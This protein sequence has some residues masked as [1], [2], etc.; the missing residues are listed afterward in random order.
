VAQMRASR[1]C[2]STRW[3]PVFPAPRS[4]L[5]TLERFRKDV[6]S[7]RSTPWRSRWPPLPEGAAPGSSLH[8]AGVGSTVGATRAFPR[9]STPEA[10]NGDRSTPPP[11]LVVVDM[12]NDFVRVGAPLEVPE[13][14][15][16]IRVHQSLLAVCRSG[17]SR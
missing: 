12:Q 16:T 4:T 14:R 2:A 10:L 9:T 8:A 1:T 3:A 11:A 17:A 15:A 5:R 7:A 6:S 13:A